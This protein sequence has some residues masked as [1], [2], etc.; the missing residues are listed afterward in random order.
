MN[1][2]RKL[3]KTGVYLDG[4][5]SRPSHRDE[6]PGGDHD[7]ELPDA[8]YVPVQAVVRGRAAHGLPAREE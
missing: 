7:P 1:P 5:Q 8:T 6:L 2:D 3:Y 4:E